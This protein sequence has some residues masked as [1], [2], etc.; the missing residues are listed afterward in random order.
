MA[1]CQVCQS[2]LS[3]HALVPKRQSGTFQS[4]GCGHR[5]ATNRRSPWI[6]SRIRWRHHQPDQRR[7]LQLLMKTSL[8]MQTTSRRYAPRPG[9]RHWQTPSPPAAN[10]PLPSPGSET[11]ADRQRQHCSICTCMCIYR[12]SQVHPIVQ[13][14]APQAR[15]CLIPAWPCLSGLS[16]GL[17]R[18]PAACQTRT[19]TRA[20]PTTA[21]RWQRSPHR[22]PLTPSPPL[23]RQPRPEGASMMQAARDGCCYCCCCCMPGVAKMSW[24]QLHLAGGHG[25]GCCFCQWRAIGGG[26]SRRT[27]RGVPW[28]CEGGAPT[29]CSCCGSDAASIREIA[30]WVCTQAEMRPAGP[31]PSPAPRMRPAAAR[32]PP[33]WG[34]RQCPSRRR[35]GASSRSHLRRAQWRR[36]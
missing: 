8:A 11:R 21:S 18:R 32:R 9:P 2:E 14:S 4:P 20:G 10:L 33:G 34:P 19:L 12:R 5:Q 16:H 30:P 25:A 7:A 35:G 13:Q 36:R 1:P 22:A 23:Q 29:T 31:A 24:R 26:P 17:Q 27:G 15:R 28:P 3:R 6:A